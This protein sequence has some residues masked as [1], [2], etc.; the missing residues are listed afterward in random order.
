MVYPPRRHPTRQ[1]TTWDRPN[2]DDERKGVVR[3]R[4][5]FGSVGVAAL[6]GAWLLFVL[7]PRWYPTA[8]EP[9]PT[10]S[11]AGLTTDGETTQVTLFHISDDGMRLVGSPRQ[12][13]WKPDPTAQARVILEAQ[14]AEPPSPLLSPIPRGTE[15]RAIYLTE[16]GDAFVDLTDEITLGH[17]GGSLE[18]LFTVYAIVNAL[19]TNLPSVNAVQLLINGQEVDT[20]VGHVDLRYPLEANTQWSAE[21]DRGSS[22]LNPPAMTGADVPQIPS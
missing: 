14:L 17:S 4:W 16:F 1:P 20:L 8:T 7:L 12:L 21:P 18:E 11:P 22:P 15:L 2:E 9:A 19:T 13:E 3:E 10:V 6:L 5:L